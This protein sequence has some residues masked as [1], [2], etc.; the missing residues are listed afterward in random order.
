MN[1]LSNVTLVAIACANHEETL[2][3][4][5]AM[6]KSMSGLNFGDVILIT[7]EKLHLEKFGIKVINIE[8]LD[9]KGYNRFVMTDLKN[10]IKTDFALLIQH[11]GYILRPEKWDNEFLKYD[12][13]GALW[14]EK[15]HFT[16]NGTEVRVGNGGFSLRSKKLLEAPNLLGLT[17]SGPGDTYSSH[18]D[19]LICEYYRDELERYG[20]K[21]APIEL[22][23][24]FSLETKCKESVKESFGFHNSKKPFYKRLIK[25]ISS[26]LKS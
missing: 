26:I 24:K 14:G 10:Y 13:I 23:A 18:E 9:Y 21:F 16:K 20:I 7:H 8:K 5:K 25:K 6:R 17:Y 22:A 3:T 19:I 1:K 2:A 12:Y 11:D 4:I 15:L